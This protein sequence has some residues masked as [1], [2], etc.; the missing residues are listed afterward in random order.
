MLSEEKGKT[1]RPKQ[2]FAK[3]EIAKSIGGGYKRVMVQGPTGFGKTV[4]GGDIIRTARAKGNRVMFTVPSISL[5]DQT[6]VRLGEQGIYDVGV[7]QADH[8]LT[9]YDAPVQVASIQTVQRRKRLPH[10][11]LVL[12][13]EAHVFYKHYT[14]WFAEWSKIPFIGLSATPWTRG[15]GSE[16][17]WQT[18]IIPTTLK[19]LI[20]DKELSDFRVFTGKKIDTT[21]VK[22]KVSREYGVDYNEKDLAK[23]ARSSDITCDIVKTWRNL[24]ENRSTLVFCVNRAHAGEVQEEFQKKGIECGY[25]DSYTSR[26]ERAEIGKRFN[27]SELKV[28][29]NVG[30]LTTGVDWDVRCI[31][32][33]RPTKSEILFTQIIGRGLRTAPGKDYCLIIDHSDTHERL[34]FVTDIH[35]DEL[36]DGKRNESGNYK[37]DPEEKEKTPTECSSPECNFVKPAGVHQCPECGFAPK[38]RS[39]VTRSDGVMV[40]LKRDK[41]I[42]AAEKRNKM[43]TT[44]AKQFFYGELMTYQRDRNYSPGWVDNKYRSYFGVWPNKIKNECRPMPLSRETQQWLRAEN[45]RWAKSRNNQRSA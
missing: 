23:A 31:V 39:E 14:E 13:D 7:I 29:A 8:P 26:D 43:W 6:V 33:A 24:A 40:E 16:G 27:A 10:A 37:T 38:R 2:A 9:N 44:Q 17:N 11:D 3:S 20:E 22:T 41:K 5:I 30:C 25:V 35:H 42:T 32:L 28:V 18:L 12:V 4:L 19:E 21:G 45:I 1:L 15:L 36:C 34:G